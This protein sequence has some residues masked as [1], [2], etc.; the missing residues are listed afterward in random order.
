MFKGEKFFKNVFANVIIGVVVIGVLFFS[1]TSGSVS[2]AL[3]KNATYKGTSTENVSLMI[4]VYWG[5]EFIEPMLD[6]LKENAVTTTFFVGG[7]WVKDNEILLKKIYDNGNEIANHGYFHKDHKKLSADRNREEIEVTHKLVKSILDIDMKLFAP[8]SGAF[9]KTTLS[10]ADK[11]GYE[12][13]MWT[14]DT[15]DWRDQDTSKIFSRATKKTEAGDLILMHPTKCTMET[16]D[17]IIKTLKTKGLNI[18]PVSQ[19]L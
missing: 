6:I 10:E 12:T 14:H 8:P 1:I 15:I 11:L 4:N 9:N 19:V 16:L 13:I 2:V 17:K 5:N 18:T 7:T 3:S